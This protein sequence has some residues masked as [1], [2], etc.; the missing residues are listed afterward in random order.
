MSITNM[1][2]VII[3][4]LSTIKRCLGR[5]NDEF[6]NELEFKQNYTKQDSVILNLQ[7]ACEACIN[8]ANILIK[9]HKLGIPQSA[10][11]SFELI[12]NAGLISTDSATALKKMVGLR[13]IA[14]INKHLSDF[15]KY[16]KEVAQQTLI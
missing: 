1:Q 15:E 3:N 11:N 14:V 10:R 2:D 9:Y 12:A 8:I 5:I 7:R 6:T 16:S 13:N 4:K